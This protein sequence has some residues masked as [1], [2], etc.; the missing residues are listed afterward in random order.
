MTARASFSQRRFLWYSFAEAMLMRVRY[1]ITTAFLLPDLLSSMQLD[2]AADLLLANGHLNASNLLNTSS[3]NSSRQQQQQQ[4][5]QQQQQRHQQ[6]QQ[7]HE[8]Q[9]LDADSNDELEAQ[10]ADLFDFSTAAEGDTLDQNIALAA[11]QRTAR[12]AKIAKTLLRGGSHSKTP[13]SGSNGGPKD[14]AVANGADRRQ[15][16]SQQVSTDRLHLELPEVDMFG[17]Y[18][19]VSLIKRCFS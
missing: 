3:N 6:Q 13:T 7:Q 10:I 17:I 18:V 15:S 4:Q 2:I 14:S 11:V 8:K 9:Q 16:Q 12:T 19:T 5:H 1:M